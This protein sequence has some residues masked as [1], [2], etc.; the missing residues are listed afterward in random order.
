MRSWIERE[1]QPVLPRL[2][3]APYHLLGLLDW[4]YAGGF[5]KASLVNV[6]QTFWARFGWNHVGLAPAWYWLLAGWTAPAAIG[7]VVGVGRFRGKGAPSV[8]QAVTLLTVAG[9]LVW[10][11]CFL[12]TDVL[13]PFVPGARYAFPA[14][15]PTALALMAGWLAWAPRRAREWAALGLLL[16]MVLLDVVSL[17]TIRTFYS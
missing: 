13:A 5:Y 10:G 12:R 14:I 6:F 16:C 9:L 8:V 15:V 1:L 7:A 3:A 2:P 17:I 11:L 4:A